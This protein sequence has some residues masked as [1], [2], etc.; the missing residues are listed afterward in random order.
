MALFSV[1]P[2]KMC[3]LSGGTKD[4]KRE[5]KLKKMDR[6]RRL[7]K[8]LL[9]SI[10][11]RGQTSS[12]Q[13]APQKS[14]ESKKDAALRRAAIAGAIGVGLTGL[15][16]MGDQKLQQLTVADKAVMV[17]QNAALLA[18]A[19]GTYTASE[20]SVLARAAK[21]LGAG[22]LGSAAVS[23]LGQLSGVNPFAKLTFGERARPYV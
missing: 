4:E 2:K 8:S 1:G 12:P 19:A 14:S 22:V 6:F 20:G 16:I 13:E 23:T 9:E 10:S 15:G 18:G 11:S 17:A 3:D 5:K 7:P 21:G